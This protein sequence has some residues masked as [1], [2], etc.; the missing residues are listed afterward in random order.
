MQSQ[1]KGIASI[2]RLASSELSAGQARLAAALLFII[3]FCLAVLS[4]RPEAWDASWDWIRSYCYLWTQGDWLI[5]YSGGFV[6]RGLAGS[7]LIPLAERLEASP[8]AMVAG[9]QLASYLVLVLM[10]IHLVRHP[11]PAPLALL[12]ALLSPAT[13]LFQ[14]EIPERGRKE[15]VLLAWAALLAWRAAKRVPL[16]SKAMLA[17]A[18]LAIT[19]LH[20]GLILFFPLLLLF[21]M[22][23]EPEKPWGF[24][25]LGLVLLPALLLTLLTAWKGP[26]DESQFQQIVGRFHG[27]PVFWKASS[28]GVLSQSLPQAAQEAMAQVTLRRLICL[29][30]S[31]LLG[32]LPAAL[33]LAS[34]ADARR[35]LGAL[36]AQPAAKALLG[37]ALLSQAAL[38]TLATDWGRWICADLFLLAFGLLAI[39]QR[40]AA[41]APA[42]RTAP[43][44]LFFASLLIYCCA[45]SLHPICKTLFPLYDFQPAEPPIIH[46]NKVL[47]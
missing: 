24:A 38:F 37:I 29:P 15:L 6:R 26:A 35:S 9:A 7:L 16:P 39:R 27:D 43:W 47:Q 36:W 22:A 20:D 33:W 3:L 30:L 34:S 10:A 23:L 40:S 28:I 14:L 46:V 18:L 32:G 44:L 2:Q 13:F 17:L 21:I 1:N 25:G 8:Y 12:L 5:N 41:L 31:F 45:W 19:A 4:C 42:P 11:R